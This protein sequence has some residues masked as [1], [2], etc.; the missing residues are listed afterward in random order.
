[1]HLNTSD[2]EYILAKFDAGVP[3]HRIVIGLQ[4]RAFLPSINV[5]T[6]E[7]CLHDNGR[8]MKTPLAA[9][10]IKDDDRSLG[11]VGGGG[12]GGVDGH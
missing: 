6:I 7:Q 1:M 11:R 9:I 12:E 5:A 4:Y 3:P 8:L 10:T 2:V